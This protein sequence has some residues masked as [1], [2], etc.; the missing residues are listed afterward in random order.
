MF[1]QTILTGRVGKDPD[2]R[3]VGGDKTVAV[4]SMVTNTYAGKT[5]YDE[6]HRV[7]VWGKTAEFAKEHI[8]KGSLIMVV[9]RNVLNEWEDK[10]TKE[11][12]SMTEILA[13]TIKPLYASG[14]SK[15]AAGGGGNDMEDDEIPF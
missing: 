8:K 4:I 15:P 5:T 11:K 10:E 1:S 12:R 13:H 2:V 14:G 6:W 7:K 9:G 3:K